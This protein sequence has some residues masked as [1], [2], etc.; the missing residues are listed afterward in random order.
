MKERL[1]RLV[2][3]RPLLVF[4]VMTAA[5][6]A[7]AYWAAT[8]MSLRV[9]I[10][11]MLPAER[12]NVKLFRKFG[13][14]FGGA[15][16]TFVALTVEEGTV[17]ERAFLEKYK[18]VTD[19]LYF[20]P[21]AIR[22]L[23]Q[24][25]ALRKTKAIHGKGGRLQIEAIMWPELPATPADMDALRRNVRAQY[26]GLLV[27]SDEKSAL[28]I[29]DFVDETDYHALIEFV[30]EL[31][32]REED[33]NTRIHAA[34]RPILLGSIYDAIPEMIAIFAL[35]SL[36]ILAILWLYF[37]SW[38]GVAVPMLTANIATIWGVGL[39]GLVEYNLD[40]LLLLL[41][42]FVFA[43]VLSHSVQ[44]TSRYLEELRDDRTSSEAV[45]ASLHA[46]LRPSTAAVITDA[47][48]FTVL[49][50]IGIPSIQTLALLCTAWLLFITPAL[51]YSAAALCLTPKPSARRVGLPLID[52]IWP[53]LRVDRFALP[54]VGITIVLLVGAFSISRGL[55]IGDASGSPILWPNSRFNRDVVAIND[56]FWRVGVDMMQVFVEGDENTMADPAV[57]RRMEELGRY[58][59]ER[60]PET[61]PA[62]SLVPV[63]KRVNGVLYE[64]D[65]SY[66]LIP[67]DP[68]EIGL[69][70]YMF[71]SRGEPGDFAA[72]TNPEW[73]I[74]NLA[75]FTKDHSGP[76]VDRAVATA[77]AY[78][79]AQEPLPNGAVFDLAGGQIGIVQA[80][81]HEIRDTHNRVFAAILAVII[82]GVTI[83]YRSIATALVLAAIL[84][85]S[86]LLAL[87]QMAIMGV[88]LSINTLPVSALGIGR[89]VD[90]GIYMIDRI[91]E[92]YQLGGG[93]F[94]AVQRAVRTAG[95][96]IVVTALTMVL[97]LIPWYFLSSLRFQ[98]EMGLLLAVILFFNMIGALV[99]VPAAILILRP[100]GLLGRPETD[101]QKVKATGATGVPV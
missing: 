47:A 23:V 13:A 57:Y 7:P 21:D 1:C 12:H 24:S 50:L 90:Y 93:L 65:P 63:V 79:A 3:S 88:G 35:S 54:V 34:G 69:N 4:L 80:I 39:M 28:I 73:R 44:F 62:I 48:G 19:D 72:Y 78:L 43:T 66:E 87:S 61:S 68:N 42:F 8:G 45:Y 95:T 2:T 36:S 38:I 77:R 37:R 15:N 32:E 14:Q 25:L 100:K 6:A 5:A 60:V 71:R 97:P 81:N 11:E 86:N 49:Y 30:G 29:A 67:D 46:L 74:G 92:E 51:I 85:T 17:Y 89:G 33:G 27:S 22:P 59:Y 40:P 56:H 58:V 76:T 83:G 55:V 41:P 53:R 91:R 52:A 18:R 94:E 82:C 20:H 64:G 99:V 75:F 26:D 31:R 84:A 101:S 96:A 16:T 70:I 9:V 98:A 10:E